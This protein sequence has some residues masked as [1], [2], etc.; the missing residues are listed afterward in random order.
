MLDSGLQSNII[1]QISQRICFSE[2]LSAERTLNPH[3]LF[4][5]VAIDIQKSTAGLFLAFLKLFFLFVLMWL[6][7]FSKLTPDAKIASNLAFSPGLYFVWTM[8]SMHDCYHFP[9]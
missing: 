4:S 6:S 1:G 7:Y 3:V 2:I 9:L 5:L 8:G